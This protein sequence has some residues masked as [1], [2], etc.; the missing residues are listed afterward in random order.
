MKRSVRMLRLALFAAVG[1]VVTASAGIASSP[2][3]RF[4]V[5]PLGRASCAEFSAAHKAHDVREA[6]LISFAEGYITAANRYE[7]NTFD[8]APWHTV[9]GIGMLLDRYCQANGNVPLIAALGKMVAALRPLRLADSSPLL[10]IADGT[11]KV[12]VYEMIL[13]RAQANLRQRGLFAGT[14]DGHDSP[15]LRSAL[16]SFQ[17]TAKFPPT[18]LPDAATL[19]ILLS[20]A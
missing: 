12:H 1:S 16:R 13:K 17:T 10:E 6:P 8:L 15:Q 3:G 4:A 14:E 7:T 5:E 19:W 2:G 20:P 18:G 11:K 9:G